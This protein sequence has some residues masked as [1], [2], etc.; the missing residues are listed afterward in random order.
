FYERLSSFARLITF[1]RRGTGLSDRVAH[2]PTLETRMDDLRAV[3]D[4]V[5]SQRAAIL[6]AFEAGSIA[7]VF[8]A[9][10][11]ER[12]GALALYNPIVR[13]SWAPDFP[14]MPTAEA[15]RRDEED[16]R[17]RWGTVEF[18][19][20]WVRLAAP[21]HA[22]DPEFVKWIARQHRL[23]A[24][25]GAAAAV[26]RMQADTDIRDVLPAVR[27]PT[28][29]LAWQGERHHSRYAAGRIPGARYVDVGGDD[30]L[31][32]LKDQVAVEV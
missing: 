19:E 25:P 14:W 4:A 17:A 18:A 8:S 21:S 3:M 32:Y 6:G 9:T 22:E 7:C 10:Y 16:Y 12:V 26:W 15:R 30:L 1:D 23:G 5:G 24:S 20:E 31:I 29:V 13:G 27:V 28:L 2:V 11:P